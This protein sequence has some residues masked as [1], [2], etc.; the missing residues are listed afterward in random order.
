MLLKPSLHSL[1]ELNAKIFRAN[2]YFQVV[3]GFLQTFH[4]ENV[5]TSKNALG[6]S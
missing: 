6:S 3:C 2:I 4:A 5:P 1:R